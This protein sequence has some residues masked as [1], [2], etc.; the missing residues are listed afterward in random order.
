MSGQT[1]IP[2]SVCRKCGR[3]IGQIRSW[4]GLAATGAD[5]WLTLWKHLA[6]PVGHRAEPWTEA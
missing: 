5:V 1:W 4:Y 6:D 2:R 3:D